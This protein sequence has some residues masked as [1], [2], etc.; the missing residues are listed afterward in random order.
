M[1][2]I[3]HSKIIW[4]FRLETNVRVENLIHKKVS[5]LSIM[6]IFQLVFGKI[7]IKT[8]ANEF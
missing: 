6:S 3:G 4:A 1:I 2:T 8:I 7:V 5:E